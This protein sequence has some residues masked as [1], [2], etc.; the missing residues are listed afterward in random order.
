MGN[1]QTGFKGTGHT[2]A[3]PATA[4]T[5]VKTSSET[6]TNSDKHSTKQS[7]GAQL[8]KALAGKPKQ[9]LSIAQRE[10][11]SK[12]ATARNGAWDEK[13]VSTFLFYMFCL[14]KLK[15]KELLTK[16]GKTKSNKSKEC[17]CRN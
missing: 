4:T 2:L 15:L 5:T 12:A 9:Q 1:S 14:I 17:T 13:L 10:A 7:I 16:I 3:A 8:S 6:I 11:M